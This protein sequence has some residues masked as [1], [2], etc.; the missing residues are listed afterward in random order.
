MKLLKALLNI[1]AGILAI[2]IGL[3]FLLVIFGAVFALKQGVS[4]EEL[5]AIKAKGDFGVA[6]VE[7]TGEILTADEFRSVLKRAVE[8]PKIKSIVVR[9]DSPGGAVA[10]S[11]EMYRLIKD[12]GEKKPIV[13]SMGN[14]A[15]S[16]GLFAALGCKKVVANESTLTGSIGVIVMTPN[17]RTMMD[18]F[19]FAMNVVK[20]GKF[21]DTG[22]P[23][24]E[25]SEEDRAF[26]QGL[27]DE[28]YM[29]FVRRV[30]EARGIAIE[31]VKKFADGRIILGSQAKEL[32]LVDEIGGIERAAK[33][34]LELA[35]I[36]AEPELI[37]VKKPGGL[38]SFLS[39]EEAKQF[40]P[41]NLL[42]WFRMSDKTQLLYRAF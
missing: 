38:V 31:D 1:I 35:G 22:S 24:R 14:L 11:E 15:A 34:S 18:K 40:L 5:S 27:I 36:Q 20:S 12:A 10:A 21:K 37:R 7:L 8:S 33:L 19:G 3:V 23:F 17:F 26:M 4:E 13:C 41:M 28:T 29:Q 9:I 30:S 39:S 6:L 16:G 25:F 2:C 42:Y 32:G